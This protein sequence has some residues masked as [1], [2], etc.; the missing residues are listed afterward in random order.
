MSGTGTSPTATDFTIDFGSNP[1]SATAK[2]GS[3]ATYNFTV[4]AT[5]TGAVFNPAVTFGCSGL[6]SKASCSFNPS[7][8]TAGGGEMLTISTTATI[9]SAHPAGERQGG[10]PWLAALV[11]PGLMF[12]VPGLLGQSRRKR[13]MIYLG[14]FVIVATIAGMSACGGGGGSKTTTSNPIPGT[15][16]GTYTV[17]ITGTYGGVTHM[18]AVTLTVN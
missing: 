6:P 7:S 4:D 9:A 10:G 18:Q 8:I 3:S 16:A 15:P 1:T 14:T 5:P 13:F 2:A 17:T 11:I 12:I